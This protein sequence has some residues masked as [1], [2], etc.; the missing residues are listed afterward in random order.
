M[1]QCSVLQAIAFFNSASCPSPSLLYV[2]PCA[3]ANK[4][5][6]FTKDEFKS[7]FLGK[8][9]KAFK[10]SL[11]ATS[12]PLVQGDLPSSWTWMNKVRDGE[13]REG[14][15]RGR[16]GEGGKWPLL[17]SCFN[18]PL[19]LLPASLLLHLQGV[20]N[21]VKDQGQCGAASRIYWAQGWVREWS[22]DSVLERLS[23]VEWE[24]WG[25]RRHAS[26]TDFSSFLLALTPH[27]FFSSFVSPPSPSSL[28]L[29]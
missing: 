13:G 6:H 8:K 12:V 28:A 14:E 24:E 22:R 4:Y 25:V 21:P 16:E 19:L 20:V 10:D 29:Q 11:R 9:P 5:A 27:I 17:C 15:E 7:K 2:S 18:T 3:A 26:V 1:G 23:R